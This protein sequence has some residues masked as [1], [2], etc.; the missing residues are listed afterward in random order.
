QHIKADPAIPIIA[1]IS[2][3][4]KKPLQH[5]ERNNKRHNKKHDKIFINPTEPHEKIITDNFTEIVI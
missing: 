1:I 2:A 4:V 5:Q 3:S